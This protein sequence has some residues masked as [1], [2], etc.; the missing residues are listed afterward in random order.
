MCLRVELWKLQEFMHR[1]ARRTLARCLSPTGVGMGKTAGEAV[2][3]LTR[4][5]TRCY[6]SPALSA[7]SCVFVHAASELE[8]R[9]SRGGFNT[10]EEF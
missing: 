9:C 4:Q 6:S 2:F 5:K 3:V 7:L 8:S 1:Y 10:K